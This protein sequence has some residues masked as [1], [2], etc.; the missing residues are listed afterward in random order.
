MRDKRWEP[1]ILRAHARKE[2]KWFKEQEEL[3]WSE[4]RADPS[5][6]TAQEQHHWKTWKRNVDSLWDKAHEASEKAGYE[7]W[8]RDGVRRNEGKTPTFMETAVPM[9]LDRCNPK[10][11]KISQ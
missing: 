2:E 9:Y 3:W 8:D 4:W 11:K 10:P 5:S 1:F 7:Y 6:W